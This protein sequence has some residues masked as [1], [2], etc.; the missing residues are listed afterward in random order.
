MQHQLYPDWRSKVKFGKDGPD[1]QVLMETD[2]LKV[3][4][5]GLEPGQKIPVHPEGASVFHILQGNG[6]IKL[7]EERMEVEAG[8][9]VVMADGA[10]RGVEASTQLVFL[11]IRA[12]L[13]SNQE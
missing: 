12:P 11:A 4:L 7:G 5:A 6:W 3:V 9:T 1:P 13:A 10:A 8:A 2:R